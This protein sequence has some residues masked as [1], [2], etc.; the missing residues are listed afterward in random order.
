M[1]ET[2]CINAAEFYAADLMKLPTVIDRL[3]PIN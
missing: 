1:F 2:I 3:A